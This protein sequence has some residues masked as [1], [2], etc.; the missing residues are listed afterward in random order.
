MNSSIDPEKIRIPA[1]LRK[2]A[3]VRQA[4]QQLILTALDRKLAGLNVHSKKPLAPITRK[5][6]GERFK[7]F[8]T[9]K[10]RKNTFPK[11]ELKN[12]KINVPKE[13]NISATGHF[14]II[15][16]GTVIDYYEKIQVAVI[17]LKEGLR[18]GDIIQ[19][20]AKNFMFQQPVE[21]MQINRKPV[22]IGKKKAEIGLK[23]LLQ[24]QING[25]VY[26]IVP[27]KSM[28]R[29]QTIPTDRDNPGVVQNAFAQPLF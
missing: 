19:V 12:E 27:A 7:P 11:N 24:P 13:I 18:I 3:I 20:T 17:R 29:F 22:K 2:K 28:E 4:R 9:L 10:S 23:V 21:S 14:L 15:P 1:F 8:P 5:R 16:I 26:K 6:V 25:A